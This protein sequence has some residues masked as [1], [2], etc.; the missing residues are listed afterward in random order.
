MLTEGPDPI[1]PYFPV[2][3]FDNKKHAS[4]HAN[5]SATVTFIKSHV[6]QCLNE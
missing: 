4:I 6:L 5:Y 1:E 3:H 2:L